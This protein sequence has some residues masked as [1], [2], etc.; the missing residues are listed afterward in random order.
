V[1]GRL[2]FGDFFLQPLQ[3]LLRPQALKL[4]ALRL[5]RYARKPGIQL[6]RS[7]VGQP[8]VLHNIVAGL[9]DWALLSADGPA[10]RFRSAHRRRIASHVVSHFGDIAHVGAWASLRLR[11]LNF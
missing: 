8:L 3:T 2:A 9:E 7:L 1:R 6:R 4:C 5:S 11:T 10:L